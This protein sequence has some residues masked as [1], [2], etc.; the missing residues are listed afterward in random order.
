MSTQELYTAL[1]ATRMD[2]SHDVIYNMDE[3]IRKYIQAERG[4]N[5]LNQYHGSD[6]LFRRRLKLI[7]CEE[8]TKNIKP[9]EPADVKG[10]EAEQLQVL[11][12]AARCPK[13]AAWME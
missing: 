1:L 13:I 5:F 12:N 6:D 10:S 9:I 11:A 3:A 7:L 2:K 8:V 4:L